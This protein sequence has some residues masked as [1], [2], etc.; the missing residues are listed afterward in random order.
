MPDG[1]EASSGSRRGSRYAVLLA[2]ALPE[3]VRVNAFRLTQ[4]PVTATQREIARQ[5]EKTR[6][7]EKLGVAAEADAG[8]MPIPGGVDAD[9]LHN[10]LQRLRDPEK[11]LIDEVFWFWPLDGGSVDDPGLAALQ[12]DDRRAAAMHWMAVQEGGGPSGAIALHNLAVLALVGAVDSEIDECN[13]VLDAERRKVL[14]HLW[15]VTFERWNALR[16]APPFWTALKRRVRQI[17]DPRLSDEVVWDIRKTLP[18][19]LANIAAHLAVSLSAAGKPEACRRVFAA[20]WA[21]DMPQADVKRAA[22]AGIEP[23]RTRLR[24]SLDAAKRDVKKDRS[25]RRPLDA[26][27]RMLEQC[28]PLLQVVDVALPKQDPTRSG[29][30]DDVALALRGIVVAWV[31]QSGDHQAVSAWL[32]RALKLAEGEAAKERIQ[33]DIRANRGILAELR[34]LGLLPAAGAGRQAPPP[35]APAAARQSPASPKRASSGAKRPTARPRPTAK[36]TAKPRSTAKPSPTAKPR[37]TAKPSPN[38]KPRPTVTPR[39]TAKPQ[40]ARASKPPSK[41]GRLVGAL[42][43]LAMLALLVVAAVASNN[44]SGQSATSEAASGYSAPSYDDSSAG[45]TE[46]IGSESTVPATSSSGGKAGYDE[47]WELRD[48]VDSVWA[49]HNS[50]PEYLDKPYPAKAT[51]LRH[52]AKEIRQWSATYRTDSKTRRYAKAA[53]RLASSLAEMLDD[54]SVDYGPYNAAYDALTAVEADWRP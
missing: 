44:G 20:L 39:P 49:V 1:E 22:R 46:S 21:S 29:L 53:G 4:L 50:T 41:R 31:N 10:A 11:R 12:S 38:A 54:P 48:L 35:E 30:H 27:T 32:E 13:G 3:L 40:P 24:A 33:G 14:P 17:D 36:P 25:G 5:V 8:S 34:R 18:E 28:E 43:A 42:V 45:A 26:S 7:A 23:I 6:M 37:S 16:K 2:E 15:K 9:A 52:L 51:Q 19:A 47:R